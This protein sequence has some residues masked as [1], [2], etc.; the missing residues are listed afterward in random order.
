MGSFCLALMLLRP[1]SHHVDL[2]SHPLHTALTEISYEGATH[3]A[4]IRIRI[5]ADDL[6][7]MLVP[8]AGLPADTVLSRYARATFAL[9]N[10]SGHP[11]VLRWEG[12][13]RVGDVVV[14]RLRTSIDG[15]MVH[16]RVLSA[17]LWE[18]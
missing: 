2:A 11:S 5:F 3:E 16:I 1:L 13:A 9:V 10:G 17:V 15:G 4:I 8:T 7:S 12:L 6:D 18:R 14:L